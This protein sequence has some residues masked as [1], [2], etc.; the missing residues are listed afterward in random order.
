ATRRSELGPAAPTFCVPSGNFGNLTAGVYAWRWGMPVHGFIAAT[1]VN[2]IVP[3]Y[4]ES[5]RF[6]PRPSKQTMSNA[7]DVGNPSNFERLEEVFKGSWQEMA[8]RIEGRSITDART[9]ETMRSVHDENG[10]LVDPHTA[11][12]CAA[13]RDH[14][15]A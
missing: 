1:N 9:M 13:A 3:V 6:D 14:L 8:S 5:G 4:L 11:V 7:M 2:D 10:V 12:G 15:A